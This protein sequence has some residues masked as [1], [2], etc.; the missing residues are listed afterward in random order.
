MF[1]IIVASHSQM[2]SSILES[3]KMILGENLVEK[4]VRAV[5][6]EHG[7][8]TEIVIEKYKTAI[9]ELGSPS[10]ILFLNDLRGGTPYNA[11]SILA[12][13]EE[14]YGIVSGVNLPMLVAMIQEQMADD[15]KANI[16]TLMEKAVDAGKAG[17]I[18]TSY[19]DLNAPHD[20]EED[21]L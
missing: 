21:D 17:V 7:E 5:N 12:V 1:G 14:S 19:D 13:A 11:A 10:R 8:D 16:L 3:C 6:L 15:G 20:D 18:P 9:K 4:G 2:A